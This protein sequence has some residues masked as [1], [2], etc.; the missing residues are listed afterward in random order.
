MMNIT[1]REFLDS[2]IREAGRQ[3]SF[4]HSKNNQDLTRFWSEIEAMA[5][6][7][8]TSNQDLTIRVVSYS[9][10]S[11]IKACEQVQQLRK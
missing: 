9:K 5:F 4:Y 7:A 10:P 3:A 1:T 8:K 2:L 6:A 11:I